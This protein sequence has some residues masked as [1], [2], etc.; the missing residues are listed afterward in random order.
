MKRLLFTAFLAL[1][2]GGCAATSRGCS[3][4]SAE[5]FGGNWVVA[6][7][8]MDGT[9]FN[10]WKLYGVAIVNEPGSDG[11]YWKDSTSPHLVHISGWYNRVQVV[12]NDWP[13]AARLLNVDESKCG[14]GV[15]PR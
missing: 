1:L 5:N 12:G 7:Y 10:C 3:R 14:N 2:V 6:Q 15:Y 11:V 4:F 9:A 8:R 13:A